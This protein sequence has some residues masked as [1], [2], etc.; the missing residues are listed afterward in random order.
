[1]NNMREV[2]RQTMAQRVDEY[3]NAPAEQQTAVLDEHIDRFMAQA[4]QWEERRKEMEKN[5]ELDRERMGRM[6]GNTSQQ[7]RKERSE[8][9]NPDQ[10]A[11]TMAYFTAVRARMTERGI[12]M[13]GGFGPRG[14]GGGSGA[15]GRRGP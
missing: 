9:R 7:E 1:M 3:F 11:R 4:A 8:A 14:M 13:P 2:W 5:G 12:K 6:F 10:M 15:G